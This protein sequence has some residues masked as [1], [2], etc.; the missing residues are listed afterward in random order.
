[1]TFASATAILTCKTQFLG[2]PHAKTPH[3]CSRASD[4][5]SINAQTIMTLTDRRIMI[6][7]VLQVHPST[8]NTAPSG[9]FFREPSCKNTAHS[10]TKCM[11]DTASDRANTDKRLTTVDTKNPA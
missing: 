10:G 3:T 2:M 7:F 6:T 4:Y 9:C 8:R 5:Q 11:S 1:M